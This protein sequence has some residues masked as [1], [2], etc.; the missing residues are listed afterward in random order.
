MKTRAQVLVSGEV[1]GVFFRHSTKREA[2]RLSL[3]GWVRNNDD[4]S[5]EALAQGPKNKLEEFVAWCKKGPPAAEI[6]RVEVV[7]GSGSGHFDNFN[8]I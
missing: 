5:V 2:E 8:I 6:E 3:V 4:G 7:W 1:Q